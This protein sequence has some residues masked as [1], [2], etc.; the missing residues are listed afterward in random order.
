MSCFSPHLREAILSRRGNRVV[1]G[2]AGC[3]KSELT[4]TVVILLGHFFAEALGQLDGHFS[5]TERNHLA[6]FR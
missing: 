3:W 1:N 4:H 2:D 5:H 6:E